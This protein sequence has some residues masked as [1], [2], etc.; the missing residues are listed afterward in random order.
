MED[1]T[2]LSLHQHTE[3]RV[4]DLEKKLRELEIRFEEIKQLLTAIYNKKQ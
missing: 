3:F 1:A 2:I 4:N